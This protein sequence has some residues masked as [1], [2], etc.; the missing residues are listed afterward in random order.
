[1]C[2]ELCKDISESVLR[3]INDHFDAFESKFQSLLSV[4]IDLQNHVANHVNSNS[5]ELKVKCLKLGKH[6]GQ[7][8]ANILDLEACSCR[9]N[10]KIVGIQEGAEEGRPKDF[11]SRPIPELLGKGLFT[12]PVRVDRAHHSLQP[13]PAAGAI[14]CA[15]IHHFQVRE[16]ILRHSRQQSIEYKGHKV[17]IFPDYTSEVTTQHSA[18]RDIMQALRD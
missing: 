17:L 1:M 11:V 5:R 8:Q 15:H 14:I 7:F 12:H 10:I 13:K 6:N 16:L 3:G 18:F 2:K 4:Q 9:H